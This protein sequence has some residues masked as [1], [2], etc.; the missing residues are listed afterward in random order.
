MLS[1]FLL[2]V[3]NQLDIKPLE[4]PIAHVLDAE[5]H[6]L[7]ITYNFSLE[8][9]EQVN[10]WI[11]A[12]EQSATMKYRGRGI[13]TSGTLYYGKHSKRWALKFYSKG[14][15]LDDNIRKHRAVNK[16]LK[17][18]ANN[19]LRAELVMRRME[20]KKINL[21]T[22]RDIENFETDGFAELFEKY[23]KGLEIGE[24]EMKTID[25]QSELTGT[26]QAAYQMWL[27][28]FDLREVYPRSTY[29]D[30]KRN[31]YKKVGVNVSVPRNNIKATVSYPTIDFIRA[32]F[33]PVPRWAIGT[34]LYFE[35]RAGLR[36]AA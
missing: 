8:S 24:C 12:T 25:Y 35:P 2:S 18:Y 11:S 36:V 16:A 21:T 33:E 15:E 26:Q 13:M 17:N 10:T 23:I 31:I 29:Y 32:E 27:Q 22:V 34:N 7:D 30:H 3:P 6:R 14:R 9:R 28:G 1:E 19:L 5:I 4:S 20:L